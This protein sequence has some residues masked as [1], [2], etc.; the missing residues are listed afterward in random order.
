[1]A[2]STRMWIEVSFNVLYLIA[3]W[4]LVVIMWR[5]RMLV[6]PAQRRA[7]QWF[8]GAFALLALG[9]TGHVG[10]RVLAYAS[11][12]LETPV[13]VLG[14]NQTLVGLGTLA[15]STT[16]TLFYV[17]MLEVWRARFGGRYGAFGIC[18]LLSALV[19]FAMMVPAAN[20]WQRVDP[21]LPYSIYRN[22]PLVVLGIGVAVLILRDAWQA[23]DR[24]FLWVG[25]MILVSYACYVPV[26]LLVAQYPLIGMLMIPKTLAYL[27]VAVIGYSAW[28][29]PQARQVTA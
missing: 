14:V 19:R 3:V 4:T 6:P 7:A 10:L 13:R 20:E 22:V 1:M 25:G 21:P 29:I 18:L 16:V 9:D 5:R 2:D 24:A 23:R 26:I 8:I 12:G 17:L 28:F 27:A 15:T 11:G